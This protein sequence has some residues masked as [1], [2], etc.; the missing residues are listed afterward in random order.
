MRWEDCVE[1][2]T[3][4]KDRP[5]FQRAKSLFSMAEARLDVIKEIEMDDESAS[6]IFTMTYESIL[7][8]AHALA[9]LKGY[10]ILD[11][12]CIKAFL[13]DIGI[14]S[15]AAKF[16]IYRKNRNSINYYGKKLDRKYVEISL[17][18][19]N[20]VIEM[21]KNEYVKLGESH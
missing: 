1:R 19:M 7:E 16:D 20:N 14:R 6:V 12:I 21:L 10:K 9:A 2:G 3:A 17:R 15:I 8:F 4:R 18:E 13:E 11:H 5:D